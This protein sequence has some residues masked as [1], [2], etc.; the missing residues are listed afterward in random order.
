MED[1]NAKKLMTEIITKGKLNWNTDF[2]NPETYR[3]IFDRLDVRD[4]TVLDLGAGFA[5]IAPQK[6][7]RV[8]TCQSLLIV[9][10]ALLQLIAIRLE[11]KVG[12]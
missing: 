12:G 2:I 11:H 8:N 3:S 4:T 9:T 1:L 10:S 6:G 5:P 7:G